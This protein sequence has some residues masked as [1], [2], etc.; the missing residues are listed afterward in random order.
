MLT[1][2][3]G[4]VYIFQA[5]KMNKFI[6]TLFDMYIFKSHAVWTTQ[7]TV[8]IKWLTGMQVKQTNDS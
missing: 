3:L 2:D 1:Y 8:I 6:T 7:N 4:F 5:K